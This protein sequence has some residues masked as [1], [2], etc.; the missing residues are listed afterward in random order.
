MPAPALGVCYYPEHWPASRWEEDARGMRG[1]GIR[2]VRIGEFAWSRLEPRPGQ[3][4]FGRLVE[5][6]DVLGRNGLQSSWAPPTT[7]PGGCSTGTPTC[8]RSAPRNPAI[9]ARASLCF[10]TGLPGRSRALTSLLIEGRPPPALA[11]EP[12]STAATRPIPIPGGATG[13]RRWLSALRHDRGRQRGVGQCVLSMEY[14]EF[15]RSTALPHGHRGQPGRLH[16]LC[17]ALLGPGGR[18]QRRSSTC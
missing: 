12:T 7:P 2:Y 16:G 9:S 11:A 8:W 4:Q 1:I 3:L 5:A 15:D 13:F 6:M 10:S 17:R 14:N 18:I